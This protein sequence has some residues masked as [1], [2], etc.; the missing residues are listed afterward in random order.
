M[1]RSATH[2]P[3]APSNAIHPLDGGEANGTDI[4]FQWADAQDP[5]GDAIG[6]YHFELSNR[7]DM[8]WPLSM[9]FYKLSSRTADA[10]KKKGAPAGGDTITVQAQYTLFQPGLLTPDRRYYWHVRAMDEKGVWGPWSRTWSFIPRGAACPL[11]VVLDCDATIG[12]GVLRWMPNPIGRSPVRYRVYGSD[13]KGFTIADQPY[14]ST[15][16][17]T[18]PE[19]NAWNPWFPANFIAETTA[20]NLAVMGCEVD[21]P[22]AN[23]T[24]YRVVAV[25][26]Q[27]KRGGPSDYATGPRMI[28]SKPLITAKVGATYRY[29]IQVN[30]SLGHLSARMKDN[31]Q[32]S[33][34]FDIE[35]PKFTLVAGP[36]WLKLDEH[37][38][39][40]SGIP[41]IAGKVDVA[42]VALA[43]R[44]A[45][46]LDEKTLVWG[47]EKVLSTR[48]EQVGAA[49]QQC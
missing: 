1:E 14:Q 35:K 26:E 6:D 7:A 29:P 3:S 48:T 20:T 15:V 41:D 31:Q 10:I 49:T 46:N 19:M 32:V 42:V 18:K 2:P 33:G 43:E 37:T 11:N 12:K 8:R 9:C 44:E 5:D 4:V 21:L 36:S 39:V 22:G 28:Y 13:E 25:D 17:V 24:Y 23:K 34:Y 47:N 16:G 45:R 40:L 38:G 27:G 30:R